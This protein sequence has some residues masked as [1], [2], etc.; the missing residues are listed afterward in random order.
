MEEKNR[1]GHR[2]NMK[3]AIAWLRY[4]DG[5]PRV[6]AK[7]DTELGAS[8][9][10]DDLDSDDIKYALR[11]RRNH[12]DRTTAVNDRQIAAAVEKHHDIALDLAPIAASD[13]TVQAFWV[14]LKMI[15]RSA[16]ASRQVDRACLEGGAAM[17]PRPKRQPV[18]QRLVPS[19][20]EVF[21]LADAISELGPRMADGRRA[22]ERLRALV[23]VGGTLG[24]RPGELAA[25]HPEWID[26]EDDLTHVIF[27]GSETPFYDREAGVAGRKI[28]PLKHRQVGEFRAVPALADVAE[29]LTTHIERGYCLADRTFTSPTG[30]APLTWGN[31]TSI[32]WRPACER[33]FGGSGK[34][35]LAAMPPKTLR[36]AAITFWL[37][38]GISLSQAAEWAGHSEDVAQRYYAGRVSP[39]FAREAALLA[40][41]AANQRRER[42]R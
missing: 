22:G 12:N 40:Q 33:V 19:I 24:G 8:I 11:R 1:A 10:L 3:D 35:E 6:G 7:P 5:D 38:S 15:I 26:V 39:G 2:K 27:R 31:I 20:Q 36:K 14:T 30:T 28:R 9:R 25:H 16:A 41:G 37:D 13:R 42:D 34:A 29:V 18:S 17:A 21:D 23:L 4:R 32:Y